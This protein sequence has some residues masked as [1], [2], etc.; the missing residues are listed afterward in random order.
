MLAARLTSASSAELVMPKRY[1][2]GVGVSVGCGASVAVN[3]GVTVRVSVGAEVEVSVGVTVAVC[4]GVSVAVGVLVRLAGVGVAAQGPVVGVGTLLP[5]AGRH[6][7]RR[8]SV[9]ASRVLP[10][11]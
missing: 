1:C 3:V 8:R 4:V 7:R 10:S 2:A 6:F 5:F 9:S 11:A